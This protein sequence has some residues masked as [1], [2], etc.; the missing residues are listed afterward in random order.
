MSPDWSVWTVRCVAA[1]STCS[2][3]TWTGLNAIEIGLA[4]RIAHY[5][6]VGAEVVH[7]MSLLSA[8]NSFNC[9]HHTSKG[10]GLERM[11]M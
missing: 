10:N 8:S 5:N 2:T 9:L 6:L 1:G 7:G 11:N 3:T 4:H